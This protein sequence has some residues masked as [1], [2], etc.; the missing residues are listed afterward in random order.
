VRLHCKTSDPSLLRWFDEFVG[1]DFDQ[2]G[3]SCGALTCELDAAAFD[4]LRRQGPHAGGA[5]IDMFAL[6]TSTLRLPRWQDRPDRVTTFDEEL[7]VFYRRESDPVSVTLIS[8]PGNVSAR[9]GLL[10]AAR[11]MVMAQRVSKGDVLVHAAAFGSDGRTHVI[12]GAKHAGKTTLLLH[13]LAAPGVTYVA[14]DRIA[15]SAGDRLEVS[16][17]PTIVS[18]RPSTLD[19][20]GAIGDALR[21]S[22]YH[23]R[24]TIAESDRDRAPR[25]PCD[26][27]PAQV[28]K[29]LG[30]ARRGTQPLGALI[31]PQ[32]THNAGGPSLRPLSPE[33][34]ARHLR[35]SLFRPGA[36][37]V[38]EFFATA[39]ASTAE[40]RTR[41]ESIAKSVPGFVCELGL[42]V[43]RDEASI[44]TE[45]IHDAIGKHGD[46]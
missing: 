33:A 30:V 2:L 22:G 27:S 28:A 26:L 11:E 40:A 23:H 6:D 17:I 1:P 46:F 42:D 24:L 18:L 10:R 5:S 19:H 32:H 13:C 44:I 15:I 34:A 7:Q 8:M 41:C 4:V 16:G 29:V 35:A 38:G 3:E 9:I 36:A 14:N 31:F 45:A 39:S 37:T 20:L 21:N 25:P 12:A 43:Y